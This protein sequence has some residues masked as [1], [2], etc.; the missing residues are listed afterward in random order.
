MGERCTYAQ[1]IQLAKQSPQEYLSL[2]TDGMQQA[3][4]LLPYHSNL[5]NF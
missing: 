1:R 3:H 2:A 5:D 4:C